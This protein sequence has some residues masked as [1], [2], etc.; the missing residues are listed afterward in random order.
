[1]F[2][3]LL[4]VARARPASGA[5]VHMTIQDRFLADHLES[6]RFE[7]PF[8]CRCEHNCN[9]L[10]P[11][12]ILCERDAYNHSW[13]CAGESIFDS[14]VLANHRIPCLDTVGHVR[15]SACVVHYDIEKVHRSSHVHMACI[16]LGFVMAY[17][18]TVYLFEYRKIHK[19]VHIMFCIGCS[20]AMVHKLSRA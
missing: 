17:L 12:M 16:L 19:V 7:C 13:S 9:G 15:V 14:F 20:F 6:I 5:H 1:M 18:A 11:K 2:F 3:V 4:A 8:S 10:T